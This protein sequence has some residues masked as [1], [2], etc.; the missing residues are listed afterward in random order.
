[1]S[2]E[3][4]K[5]DPLVF[6]AIEFARK[7]HFGQT[8]KNSDEPYV[9]HPIEV[10]EI[11][12]TMTDDKNVLTAA[13]LHDT[14]EDT[15]VTL[16]EIRER[17]GDR[18]AELVS[19]DTENKREDQPAEKTWKIRKQETIDFLNG[20]ADEQE[21]M[22]IL[23]DKLS[24]I[25]RIAEDYAEIGDEVWQ[26]FHQKDKK[27]QEWYYRSILNATEELSNYSAWQEYKELID[28]IFG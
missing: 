12:S 5:D 18:V 26:I 21:K 7:A 4:Y 10:M 24:N 23:G 1:M 13:V 3:S 11:V 19:S 6:D 16:E 15:D 22:L 20:V 25:R 9:N 8:R 14:V 27:E 2:N 17:F 28:K